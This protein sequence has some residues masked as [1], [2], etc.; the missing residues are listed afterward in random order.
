M[1]RVLAQRSD[2]AVH[3]YIFFRTRQPSLQN[4]IFPEYLSILN[5]ETLE[6]A[7]ENDESV[8]IAIAV[9][10]GNVRLIDNILVS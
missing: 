10:L 7:C 9:K 3:T 8:L 6:D 1:I 2:I 4:D 5:P